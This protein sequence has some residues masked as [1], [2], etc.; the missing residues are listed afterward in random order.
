MTNR[1]EASDNKEVYAFSSSLSERLIVL[2]ILT[3]LVFIVFS[4]LHGAGSAEDLIYASFIDLLLI[5]GAISL[6]SV[7][8]QKI[9]LDFKEET[10]TLNKVIGK[11]VI[12]GRDIKTWGVR[13]VYVGRGMVSRVL[14]IN[15]KNG[16]RIIYPIGS[17][18]RNGL[19]N[20]IG[21]LFGKKNTGLQSLRRNGL[22][23]YVKY[24]KNSGW[25]KSVN[26]KGYRGGSFLLT[27]KKVK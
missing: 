8:F 24:S 17:I 9:K 5:L 27:M 14:E 1:D 23:G 19:T 10:L 6:S 16:E 22:F 3:L 15:K 7:L 20:K 18:R 11:E 4:I 25:D 13:S 26:L 2:A 21:D 12:K